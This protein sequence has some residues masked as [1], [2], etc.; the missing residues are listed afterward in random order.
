MA[1]TATHKWTTYQ[2]DVVGAFLQAKMRIRVFIKLSSIYGDLFLEFAAYCGRPV[3]LLNAM[4][5]MT[6]SGKYWYEEFIDSLVSGF[7]QSDTCAVL[8]TKHEP[9][10]SIL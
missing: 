3:V 6:L 7:I 10:G 1:D 8:F 2:F 9:G 5:G 4:Y